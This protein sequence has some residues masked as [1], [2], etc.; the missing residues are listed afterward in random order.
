MTADPR[1]WRIEKFEGMGFTHGEAVALADSKDKTGVPVYWGDVQNAIAAGATEAQ[2]LDLFV[3][4]AVPSTAL[5]Y[6]DDA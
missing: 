6:E 2:A 4:R 1:K 5:V 3:D